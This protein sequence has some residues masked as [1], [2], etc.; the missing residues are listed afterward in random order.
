MNT[1]LAA[2]AKG[3]ARRYNKEMSRLC[4]VFPG[5]RSATFFLKHLKEESGNHP[6]IAPRT[7]TIEEL[8]C[9]L[10]GTIADNRIDLL[11]LLYD[12][13]REVLREKGITDKTAD[14]DLFRSWGETVLSDFSDVDNHLADADQLFK[15]VADYNEISTD[16]LTD[17]QKE[18]MEKYF[19]IEIPDAHESSRTFWKNFRKGDA[20]GSDGTGASCL[21]ERFLYLWQLLAPIYHKFN[22]RLRA[23][24]LSYPG[25]SARTALQRLKSDGATLLPDDKYVFVGFNVLTSAEWYLFAEMSK[26]KC[27]LPG[28]DEPMADFVWDLNGAPMAEEHNSAAHFV[29]RDIKAF[30]KPAW[31]DLTEAESGGVPGNITVI[32]SPSN[33][34]QAKIVGIEL[35][36]LHKMQEQKE[37]D[38][39]EIAV[40]LPDENLL[41]PLL[42]SLPETID[43]VNLTMGCSLRYT[44]CVSFVHLLSRLHA[45][46]RHSGAGVFFFED[47]DA[48]L[49]HPFAALL[50]GL[51]KLDKL[52]K[53]LK[54]H[55]A[56]IS[57]D[58][59][60]VNEG[61]K[62]LF[63]MLPQNATHREV[64]DYIAG[65]LRTVNFVLS[66]EENEEP[67][68]EAANQ[69]EAQGTYARSWSLTRAVIDSYLRALICLDTACTQRDVKPDRNT[70]FILTDRLIAG[71]KINFEGKPLQGLQ[72]MGLLETR[73]LDFKHLV[74][75]S[76]N[77][78][79]F[80]RRIRRKTFIPMSLR[81]GFGLPTNISQEAIFAYYFYRMISRA[82]SVTMIYDA[83]NDGTKSGEPSRFIHQLKELYA[84]GRIRTVDYSFDLLDHETP[85]ITV[86]K[87]DTVMD[88][89]RTFLLPAPERRISPSSFSKYLQCPLQFYYSYILGIKVDEPVAEFMTEIDQGNV[90]HHAMM[91]L[92][93]GDPDTKGGLL[94]E[95]RVLTPDTF[96]KML[97]PK[98]GIIR[99]AVRHA[100]NKEYL[101]LAPD[102]PLRGEAAMQAKV[103]EKIVRRMVR[104]D[105]EYKQL[106]IIGCE[107]EILGAMPV[108]GGRE[109]ALKFIIDRIDRVTGQ[110]GTKQYRVVD[111]KTGSANAEA[112]STDELFRCTY[113][114]KYLF[115]LL[116][117]CYF[118]RRDS[119]LKHIGHV[120]PRL[121]DTKSATMVVPKIDKLPIADFEE[122]LE[123]DTTP[124][125]EKGL[126]V[127]G[128]SGAEIFEEGFSQAMEG[129]FSGTETFTQTPDISVCHFCNFK[130]VCRR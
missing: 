34:F 51:D 16:Y 104:H 86:K 20:G 46:A 56:Y 100:I 59:L 120:A 6:I 75:P 4:F 18:V 125:K 114:S 23:E 17:E 82:E 36:K 42:H 26:M 89:L 13:Y 33:A 68:E 57:A 110:D 66:L 52:K 111:Y 122:K 32:S 108:S 85:E 11:F 106:E 126:S 38:E 28:H 12:C 25:M 10:S 118:M 44:P 130:D 55:R 88:T 60:H 109:A 102:T 95:P 29:K 83:R 124:G 98:T 62:A 40:V 121:F 14:F 9:R 49:S 41:L 84:R 48:I 67:Q 116:F 47:V 107:V 71:E 8:M 37:F 78:R 123:A 39:A 3:Y 30:N 90:I 97:N 43:R 64:T 53:D 7:C 74:I 2:I 117:Y 21:H 92:Y 80:P 24:G 65:L 87:S 119:R 70:T 1:F 73:S 91:E 113:N 58:R 27:R 94:P 63:T 112:E 72:I 77:E 99:D 19:G 35:Q 93:M 69:E 76:M 103:I 22:G 54:R 101:N 15:N 5:R 115:Q 96:G 127:D 129:L 128:K 31:L 81:I 79:I 45:R 50:L 105:S 61:A